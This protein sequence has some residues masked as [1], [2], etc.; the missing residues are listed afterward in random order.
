MIMHPYILDKASWRICFHVSLGW[1]GTLAFTSCLL[2]RPFFPSGYRGL[3][4]F[5]LASICNRVEKHALHDSQRKF[6]CIEAD[7][8]REELSLNFSYFLVPIVYLEKGGGSGGSAGRF[9]C[10][11][12]YMGFFNFHPT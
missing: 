4:S 1:F 12:F 2:S 11:A 10:G 6:V 7:S 5:I 3:V 8:R 9:D